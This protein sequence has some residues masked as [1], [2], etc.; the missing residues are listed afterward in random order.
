VQVLLSAWERLRGLDPR[1]LDGA[2]GVALL[3]GALG[4]LLAGGAGELVHIPPVIGT[5]VP[6][7]WR[8]RRPLAVYGI[9]F[10]CALLTLEP[11][12]LA[13]EVALFFGLY[14][15]S[16]HSSRRLLSLSAPVVSAAV[17]AVLFPF[18]YPAIPAWALTLIAGLGMWLAGSAVR[19]RQGRTEALEQRARQLEHER[20]LAGRMAVAD[21]RARIA[22]ELHDVIAHS[23]SVMVVQAGAGRRLLARQPERAG[24]A[25]REVESSGRDALTEL[26]RLLGVLAERPDELVLAP[27]P[28]LGQLDALVDRVGSAGVPVGL[29]VVGSPR[30]LPPGLDLAAY[31]IL[32]EALTNV[33]KHAAGARTEVVVEYGESDLRLAVVDEGV[34]RSAGPAVA[35]RGLLGMH[36]RA[37]VYGGDVEA[38][39]RPEGG[40]AVRARLPLEPA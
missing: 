9:Q 23:V 7:Y 17:L 5:I 31:R 10:A 40:F 25:M 6:L 18:S 3:A 8:R 26:R 29:R 20:E 2:A 35:G 11:P 39:S 24:E 27:Q 1:L 22:R 36:E 16:V 15:A 19:E 21:E 13:S 37:A 38:A 12:T 32:Q 34:S 33:L 4:Q 14:S 30:P 28:G